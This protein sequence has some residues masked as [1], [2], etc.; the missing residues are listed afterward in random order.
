MKQTHRLLTRLLAA[1]AAAL[2]CVTAAQ[3]Q[4]TSTDH[5]LNPRRASYIG[6]NVG[7]SDFSVGN[8]SGIF[9]AE[10]RDTAYSLY[11]GNYLTPNF[12]VEV[13]YVDF[14][15]IDRAG[16]RTK[17]EGINLSVVGK[18]P[19]TD[20]F[21]LLGKVGTTYSRTDVS[22]TAG[23]GIDAGN[24][25]DFGWSFGV[26]AEYAFTP[27]WSVTLQYDEHDLK[28]PGGSRSSVSVTSLGARYRF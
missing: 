16:G 13:G 3:A 23:S 20:M 11:M 4:S 9:A 22:S 17:A 6:L 25:T 2:A 12:G 28:Y 8:G 27:Q 14:G 7:E 19:L 5:T 24:E 1:A 18:L 26:G 21:N 15:K 10:R